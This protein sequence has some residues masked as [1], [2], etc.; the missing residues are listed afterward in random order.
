MSNFCGSVISHSG[1]RPGVDEAAAPTRRRTPSPGQSRHY[2]TLAY[3][4]T[5]VTGTVPVSAVF[6][7]FRTGSVP[8]KK[9]DSGTSLV[10]AR[11]KQTLNR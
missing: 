10:L 11:I 1:W 7:G 5:A 9:S 6:A 2:I 8:G 4:L 3:L